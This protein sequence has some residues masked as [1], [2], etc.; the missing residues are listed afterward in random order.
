MEV[1]SNSRSP[2]AHQKVLPQPY[3]YVVHLC[4]LC[5]YSIHNDMHTSPCPLEV[6]FTNLVSWVLRGVIAK[7]IFLLKVYQGLIGSIQKAMPH[8]TP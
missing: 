5:S 1:E 2:V 4:G 3:E 8:G 6:R 7:V